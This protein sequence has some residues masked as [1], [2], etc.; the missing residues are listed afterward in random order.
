VEWVAVVLLGAAA[1]VAMAVIVSLQVLLAG[2][3][4]RALGDDQLAEEWSAAWL[5]TAADDGQELAVAWQ[6]ARSMGAD[7]EPTSDSLPAGASS[8]DPGR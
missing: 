4:L 3:G 1:I 6:L 8:P 5:A 2:R 7:G